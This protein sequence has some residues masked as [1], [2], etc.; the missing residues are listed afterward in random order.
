MS[1]K[2]CY[3]AYLIRWQVNDEQTHW[4]GSVENAYT[5]EKVFFS[6]KTKLMHFLWH[7]VNGEAMTKGDKSAEL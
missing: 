5:G 1:E 6:D 3:T 4:R 2:T 7:S